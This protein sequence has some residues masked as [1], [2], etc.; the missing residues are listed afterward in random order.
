MR[1]TNIQGNEIEITYANA[2]M[3][4][5]GHKKIT[6]EVEFN[7]L[8]KEFKATTSN[9]PAYDEAMNIEDME[10]KYFA[11]YEIIESQIEDNILD[12]I[13]ENE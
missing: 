1:T 2:L 13:S 4:G 5:Y 3:S 9:M 10:D 6:V 8:R 11:L 7:G 12:W